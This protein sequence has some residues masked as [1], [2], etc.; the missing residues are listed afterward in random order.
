MFQKICQIGFIV[1]KN[2][3]LI[4]KRHFNV[5][6]CENNRKCKSVFLYSFFF[7]SIFYP[8]Y[9]FQFINFLFR[10]PNATFLGNKHSVLMLAKFSSEI[11]SMEFCG[12][13]DTH[14]CK[15]QI[16]FFLNFNVA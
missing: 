15:S 3:Y 14:A 16:F 8:I 6:I 1:G 12:S 11:A 13:L 7:L 10:L 2:Y 5:A 9:Q 4:E